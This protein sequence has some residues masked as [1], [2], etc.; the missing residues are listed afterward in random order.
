VVVSGLT[1]N[2]VLQQGFIRRKVVHGIHFDFNAEFLFNGSEECGGC[3][4]IPRAQAIHFQ[5]GYLPFRNIRK[6]SE[7]A[8][9]Q[10][11]L[12]GLQIRSPE[13]E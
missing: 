7:E 3:N 2:K 6:N 10:S 8:A 4:R 12:N 1:C 13:Y 11:R 9:F 5:A